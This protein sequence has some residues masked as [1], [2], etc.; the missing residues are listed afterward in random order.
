MSHLLSFSRKQN[1]VLSK[2]DINRVIENAIDLTK[3]ELQTKNI[4]IKLDYSESNLINGSSNHLE[5]VFV[6]LILNSLDAII[7]KR[8]KD[9]S[10]QAEIII[11][12]KKV[13]NKIFV[14]VAD[15]GIGIP[16]NSKDK[17]FDPF[18]TSKTD[19]KGTG[20]GLS[21]SY[22]IIEKHRGDIS[23]TSQ[24]GIGT[25]FIIELPSFDKK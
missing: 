24:I 15:N 2:I 13:R 22:N 5:Q 6:N 9:K 8:E 23:F 19:G 12:V 18:Y 16:D 14:Y 20:L 17:I 7:E 25:E 21:V 11:T 4:S 1:I 10:F 3:H